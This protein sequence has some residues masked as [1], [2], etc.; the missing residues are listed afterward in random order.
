MQTTSLTG[1]VANTPRKK[2]DGLSYLWVMTDSQGFW[3][4]VRVDDD[5]DAGRIAELAHDIVAQYEM[6]SNESIELFLDRDSLEWGSEW[7][8]RIG[9]SLASVAFFVPILTP[10]YFASSSCR[11]EL[12]AFARRA[13]DLG[14]GE[15]LLPILYMDF[16][17]RDENPPTDELVA[18]V[19][20]FQWV[21]WRELRFADRRSPEYRRGVSELATRLV[22]ANRSAERVEVSDNAINRAGA[23]DDEAGVMDLLAGMETA[24]PKLT[25]TLE[26]IV[27]VITEISGVA[28]ST[29]GELNA[30]N[31][32]NQT[33]AKRLLLL[34]KFAVEM[35]PPSERIGGLGDDFA[36]QLHDVDLGVRAIIERAPDE[37]ESRAEFCS[38]FASLRS[39]IESSEA[40]LGALEGFVDTF[41]PLERLS[42]DIRPVL[43]NIRRG[44][45]L[46]VEGRDVMRLWGSQIDASGI[47][48][49]PAA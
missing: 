48:C 27:E 11:S 24:L 16:P 9:S 15:L 13:S 43:R 39:M 18:L 33:F 10:R 35:T 49:E 5:A 19:K 41:V 25:G 22:N 3:S 40:G 36:S 6:M 12:N 45:T 38:F 47:E 44:L 28:E 7:E 1:Q 30:P 32:A 34:R 46:M 42:R 8:S 29:T 17:G 23:L 31:G 20:R 14:V 4:Y 26:Q 37:P 2:L 21:D